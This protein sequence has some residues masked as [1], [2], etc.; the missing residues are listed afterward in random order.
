M[1]NRSNPGPPGL[2]G[3]APR[4]RSA[5]SSATAAAVSDFPCEFPGCGRRFDIATGR[6]LH[7]R[8]AHLDWYDSR[9]NVLPTKARW[10]EEE[11]QLLARKEA[12]LTRR[13]VRFINQALEQVFPRSLENIKGK[14]KQPEYR[15]LV[16]SRLK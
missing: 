13:G 8:R 10:N 2:R 5:T 9:Q 3:P 12:E 1:N 16:V 4:T 7:H 11:T 6:G 15:Q 14:R